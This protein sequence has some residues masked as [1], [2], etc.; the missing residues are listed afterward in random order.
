MA[1]TSKIKAGIIV[2]LSA[3]IIAMIFS[4]SAQPSSVEL[5][6]LKRLQE[7]FFMAIRISP[8]DKVDYYNILLDKRLEELKTVIKNR[9]SNLILTSSL[10]YSTT[11][12]LMT[13]IIKSNRLIDVI[14]AT[15]EKFKKHQE[16]L[17]K[18]DDTYPKDEGEEWKFIQDDYNYL[19][20]Y[21]QQLT[22]VSGNE[23]KDK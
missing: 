2:G 22:N 14:N 21:L 18:L 11:A 19:S 16:V 8:R 20:I 1:I 10:R 7:K 12:G 3:L 5:Y 17:K 9:E 4:D 6:A 15:Q 13:E 23:I